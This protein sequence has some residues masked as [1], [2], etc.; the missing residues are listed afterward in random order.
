MKYL[1][2]PLNCKDEYIAGME[3]LA[4]KTDEYNAALK[5]SYQGLSD[6]GNQAF[7]DLG[8]KMQEFQRQYEEYTNG[9]VEAD[10]EQVKSVQESRKL[11]IDEYTQQAV[12]YGK[13]YVSCLSF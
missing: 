13:T 4:G 11:I 1:V 12:A 7:N 2:K 10:A 9:T 8:T 3:G 6:A 5:L